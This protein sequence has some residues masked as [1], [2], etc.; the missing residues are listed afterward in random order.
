VRHEEQRDPALDQ[1]LLHPL[2]RLDVEMV[3]RLVEQ[4]HAR[5]AHQRPRQQRLPLAP[6]GERRERRVGVEREVQQHGLDP[7]LHLPGVG[8]VERLVQ[9]LQLLQRTVARIGADAQ[10]RL[11]VARQQPPGLAQ[12][13]GH[14]VEGRAVDR[15]GHLLLQ[16]GDGDA[17]LAHDVARVGA[18][19]PSSSAISVL[20]P[21][22]LRPRRQTRSPRSIH[23]SA[24]SR[25]GGPPKARETSLESE[26]GHASKISRLGARLLPRLDGSQRQET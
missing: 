3:R 15:L 17:A 26:Q 23:R 21:A 6:A 13:L 24:W 18:S 5:L 25:S 14:H 12:P 16:P 20:L 19:V 8:R 2:D 9:P 1:E 11:V 10:A 4:Q 22:P 7:R